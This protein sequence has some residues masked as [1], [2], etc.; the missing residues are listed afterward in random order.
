MQIRTPKLMGIVFALGMLLATASA[1]IARPL[2]A[3]RTGMS[4]ARCHI[5]PAG[6]GIRNATGFRYA[7]NG[8]TMTPEE[9]REPTLDPRIA[10]GIRLGGDIR[11]Q[12]MQDAANEIRDRSTFFL[13]QATV[14][15]AAELNERFALVYSNDQ[16]RTAEAFALIRFPFADASIKAGRFRPAFGIEEEDHTTFTRDSLGFGNG[17][18]QTGVEAAIP[19]GSALLNLAIV[20][21][22][23][24]AILDDNP[25]KALI[26][27]LAWAPD[28]FGFGVSGSVDSPESFGDPIDRS[29]RFGAFGHWRQGRLVLMGEYDRAVVDRR[30]G[31][32][33]ERAAAFVEADFLLDDRITARVKLDRF[34]P[35]LDLA[36]TARDRVAVGLE[37]DLAPAVRAIL[38]VRGTRQYGHDAEGRRD[39][40]SD[41]DTAE[42]VGQL[43]VG[44]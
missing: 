2:Y 18:E 35:N 28:G 36:E 22:N 10:D 26:G 24:G 12:Y 25:Q 21:G 37:S 11:A 38:F 42:I 6:G 39:Y 3:A 33:I 14:H 32:S 4:C 16:G 43:A 17:A 31:D 19:R 13:M 27:R 1:A 8:H 40:G 5:D 7:Q 34:D 15:L 20:N 30:R 23:A 44:F 9:D 41:R 29:Y